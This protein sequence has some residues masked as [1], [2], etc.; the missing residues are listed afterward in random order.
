M[1]LAGDAHIKEIISEHL[2]GCI[3][4]MLFQGVI[5][6]LTDI[7]LM[8]VIHSHITPHQMRGSGKI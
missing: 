1:F 5:E 4:M 7:K 3:S 6:I 2:F 8:F